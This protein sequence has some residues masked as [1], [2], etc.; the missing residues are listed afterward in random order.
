MENNVN[1]SNVVNGTVVNPGVVN[2]VNVT[3]I[4]QNVNPNGEYT[5]PVNEEEQKSYKK[6]YIWMG[7]IVGTVIMIACVLLFFLF[8]G[9]IENR[10]RMTC[11][12]TT[13]EDKFDYEIKRYY[14]FDNKK[15]VRVYYTYTF[16]YFDE[17]TE[18]EYNKTFS[19]IINID[20]NI[21]STK[22]GLNTRIQKKDNIVEITSYEPNYFG[23]FYKDLYKINTGNGYTCD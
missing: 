16:D 7:V 11:I 21:G 5:Q 20:N 22:Y 15:M 9:D 14:T 17:L 3:P 6:F 10:N 8:N 12:K 1:N 2:P 13:I 4:V 23:E 18:E 19:E